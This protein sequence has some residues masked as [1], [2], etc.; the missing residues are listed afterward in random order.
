MNTLGIVAIAFIAGI[1]LIVIVLS[2][3]ASLWVSWSALKLLKTLTSRLE[4]DDVA[5]ASHRE[6][7]RKVLESG[8]SVFQGIRSEMG[9]SLDAQNLEFKGTMKTFEEKFAEAIKKLNGKAL[10]EAVPKIASLMRRLEEVALALHQ[11]VISAGETQGT[12][13]EWSEP[14]RADEH[15]PQAE[16]AIRRSS[17]YDQIDEGEAADAFDTVTQ[18]Q[19]R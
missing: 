16:S 14:A 13:A 12:A 15:A 1:F 4:S 18:G 19:F 2:V 8:K 11:V 10:I 9:K 5:E 7:M 6:E 17:I 3:G